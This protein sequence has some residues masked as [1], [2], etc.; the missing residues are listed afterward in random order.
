MSAPLIPSQICISDLCELIQT[1]L[2]PSQVKEVYRA[3]LFSAEAHDGQRRKSGEPYVLHPL[4]VAYILAHL[5]VDAQT[6]CAALLHDVLEDT[7]ISKEN[8]VNEFGEPVAELVDGVSK[9][10]AVQF[11]TREEAQAASFRKMLLAMSRDLRVIL[12]KLA[13][14]LHNLRTLKV[15]RPEA[16][17]RIAR[18]TL[19]IYAP[20]ANR[21][22]MNALRIELEELSFAALYPFRYQVIVLRA[23]KVSNKHADTVRMIQ[24]H[25]EQIFK[26]YQLQVQVLRRER[27]FYSLYYKMREKKGPASGD[28]RKTFTQLTNSCA[29]RLVVDSKDACYRALGIVH[30]L[31][32]PIFER[33][34]DYIA[35][36]KINGYQSL[37]TVLFSP[38]GLHVEIQIRTVAMHEVSERGIAAQ[39]WYQSDGDSGSS[40]QS[41]SIIARQYATEWLRNL[42]EIAQHSDSNSLDFLNQIKH[43]LFP[44][45]V[46]VFTPQ[47]KILQ[48]PKGSTA[49]D[50][51][52]AIH[53]DVGNQCIAAKVESQYVS[54]FTPLVSGQTIEVITATWARP[55]P[56][57]LDFAVSARARVAIRQFLRNLQHDEAILLGKRM[58]DK[59]L[60]VYSLSVDKLTVEQRTILL[61][62]FK[63]D[64]INKLLADIGLGNQIAVFV[65]HQLGPTP[66][67]PL[68]LSPSQEGKAKKL[69]IKGTDGVVVNLS[70]CCRPIPGDAI[71]GFISAGRGISIHTADCKNVTDNRYRPEKFLPVEWESDIDGEF[72]VDIRVEVKDHRGVL[73][74]VAGAITNLGSNIESV[75]NEKRDGVNSAL[76]FCISVKHRQHL[77]EVMRHLHRLDVVT[78]IQRSRG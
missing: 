65:A 60:T 23:Q 18:E 36:P 63:A 34:K 21:L 26:K 59:E 22:G 56:S 75:A 50:F 35:I 32:K 43:D 31:Y 49:I 8:L 70:R 51:A 71:A 69:M 48:L 77:E 1:Y 9:L 53:S 46:Y 67:S 39:T 38:Y 24:S 11:E 47:G 55:N 10:S 5:R 19:E 17:R 2:E 13:D 14:R 12:V 73:A 37:H 62:S 41:G 76:K 58:L 66:V 29:F 16:R 27:H 64:S 57:W 3:F 4:T 54:L 72:L 45:E 15:M 20:L 25:L 30:N 7:C 78:K 33:F 44:E 28:K 74:T 40:H 68:N 6:L 42:V 61:K 52:Y